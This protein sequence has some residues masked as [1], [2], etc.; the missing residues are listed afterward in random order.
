MS[1][2]SKKP[3]SRD[4]ILDAKDIKI[5]K[6]EA[7]EWGGHT[8]VKGMTGKGRGRFD[9]AVVAE[10]GIDK[11]LNME[12]MRA[13]LLSQTLCNEDGVLL[14]SAKDIDKLGDKSSAPLQRAFE[15]AQRLS[16]IG[17]DAIKEA[18]EELEESPLEGSASD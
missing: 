6:V 11:E 9:T 1:I 14:F 17:K 4:D 13:I 7:P 16:G 8:F 2:F 18:V 12:N 3:L 15:V 5:E 10:R